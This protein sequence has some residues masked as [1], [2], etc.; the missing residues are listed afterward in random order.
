MQLKKVQYAQRNVSISRIVA[1]YIACPKIKACMTYFCN[2]M[3]S[4][5]ILAKL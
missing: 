5:D 2:K 1:E 3:G 4:W